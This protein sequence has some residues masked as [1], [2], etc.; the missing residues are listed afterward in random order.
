MAS[1]GERALAMEEIRNLVVQYPHVVDKGDFEAVGEFYDGVTTR[2]LGVDGE[3]TGDEHTRNASEVKEFYD[4][5]ITVD[6]SGRPNT[7]H[8]VSNVQ[9]DVAADCESATARST[10][11]VLNQGDGFPLQV[12]ITGTYVDR[13]QRVDGR[14]LLR[15]RDEHMGLLGDLTRHLKIDLGLSE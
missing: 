10:F 13:Y 4:Q 2:V 5:I 6:G 14:W 11:T 8:L 12:I 9:V 3:P 15:E 1:D 7:Q